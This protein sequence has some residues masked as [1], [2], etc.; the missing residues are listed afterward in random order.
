M[1]FL[2]VSTGNTNQPPTPPSPELWSEMGKFMDELTRAGVLIATG[3]VDPHATHIKSS[4]GK[5]SVTDGPF[6]EAKEGIISYALI[7]A[8]SKEE[9]IEYSKRF[10]KLAGDGQ[11]DIYQVFPPGAM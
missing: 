7:N 4:K 6:T 10:W 11:G 2:M 8:Q 3:G 9:A 1:Q 5:I